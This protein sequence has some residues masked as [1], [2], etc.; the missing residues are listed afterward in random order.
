[1]C[2]CNAEVSSRSLW[3]INLPG[4]MHGWPG[5]RPNGLEP[6]V[7][8]ASPGPRVSV[9]PHPHPGV[10][11][12]RG[13]VRASDNLPAPK[14]HLA[15]RSPAAERSPCEWVQ[16]PRPQHG[17]VQ[18]PTSSGPDLS[19]TWPLRV[20]T[21]TAGPRPP[22]PS[23]H[24]SRVSHV[25]TND[26]G[27]PAAV[28]TGNQ[29]TTNMCIGRRTARTLTLTLSHRCRRRADVAKG[30]RPGQCYCRRL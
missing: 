22:I 11:G 20:C 15:R 29:L 5:T 3:C 7:L 6:Q 14:L 10:S 19:Q 28:V 21:A 27:Q 30:P 17:A 13:T 12:A 25:T 23:Q 2:A 18:M 26:Q 4:R 9:A 1:M 16:H 24:M 8:A